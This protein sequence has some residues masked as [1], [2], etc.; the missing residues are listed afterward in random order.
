VQR[1][2]GARTRHLP[3]NVV[4]HPP[5]SPHSI[6]SSPRLGRARGMP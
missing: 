5:Q 2:I 6:S 4:N 1:G 3:S